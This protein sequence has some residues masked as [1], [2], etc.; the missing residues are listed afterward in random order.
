VCYT[1]AVTRP[2]APSDAL[3][4]RSQ[5]TI[6]TALELE[7]VVLLNESPLRQALA[8]CWPWADGGV[9]T[10]VQDPIDSS[11]PGG[12]IQARRRLG[13]PEADL[14]FVAPALNAASGAALCWQRLIAEVCQRLGAKGSQRI[15]VAIGESDQVSLQLLRQLGF[16][17]H[18]S[19]VVFQRVPTL[20][21]LA[22]PADVR[23]APMGSTRAAAV[24]ALAWQDEPGAVRAHESPSGGE[25]RGYPLGGRAPGA[26]AAAVW[27]DASGEVIGG[28]RLVAGR[29]GHWLQVVTGPGADPTLLGQSALAAL[30]TRGDFPARPVYA[31][32][33]GHEPNL[34]LALR[35]LGFT[36]V[37]GRFRLVKH[38]TVRVLEP[39]W[40]A[41]A[42][43]RRG[44]DTAPTHPARCLRVSGTPAAGTRPR[45]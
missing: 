8:S 39:A 14:T 12:F 13:R 27:L 34:N 3:R 45:S 24:E 30:A 22:P 6:G 36:P 31:T 1:W 21:P 2:F 7:A 16:A 40:H 20:P 9:E 17:V 19:D 43:R 41:T 33:R 5:Q 26:T 37:A 11:V 15:Y 4:L 23:L 25:W 38:T 10:L 35:E 32:A 42:L 18:T 29:A 44:L 28:W